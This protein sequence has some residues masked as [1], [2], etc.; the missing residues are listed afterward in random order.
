MVEFE[1]CEG[2]D[3]QYNGGFLVMEPTCVKLL[4]TDLGRPNGSWSTQVPFGV[5]GTACSE[6]KSRQI[7]VVLPQI[8]LKP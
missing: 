7:L 3:A 5:S 8:G 6:M 1:V 4:I 2:L